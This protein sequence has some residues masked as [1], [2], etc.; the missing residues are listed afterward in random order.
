[1]RL[2][3]GRWE[4]LANKNSLSAA[5]V[6]AFVVG[7]HPR[8][9]Q[10]RF[11][12]RT[13]LLLL[14]LPASPRKTPWR[15]PPRLQTSLP[16]RY[17]SRARLPRLLAWPTS[18]GFPAS[19]RSS[20]SFQWSAVTAFFNSN[21]PPSKETRAPRSKKSRASST[22][23]S[24]TSRRAVCFCDASSSSSSSSDKKSVVVVAPH[25]AF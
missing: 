5:N 25:D 24:F 7:V 17:R 22:R 9:F 19:T 10:R 3:S 13:F 14:L 16:L 1:M 21:P 23:S 6:E 18:R 2:D 11:V 12:K 4:S 8:R 20:S 15:S